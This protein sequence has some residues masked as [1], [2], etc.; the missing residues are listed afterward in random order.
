MNKLR[1]LNIYTVHSIQN[2]RRSPRFVKKAKRDV[3]GIDFLTTRCVWTNIRLKSKVVEE[4]Y[5]ITFDWNAT[6]NIRKKP[7]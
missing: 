4:D 5:F 3:G 1:D 6:I 2:K 7:I